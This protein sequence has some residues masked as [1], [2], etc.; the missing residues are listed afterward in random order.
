[1]ECLDWKY[2][3]CQRTARILA[4]LLWFGGNYQSLGSHGDGDE[5]QLAL[6]HLLLYFGTSCL[7]DTA[8]SNSSPPSHLLTPLG[9][10]GS[11]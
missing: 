8:R 4:W 6:V 3:E 1:M 9:R 2:G 11:H 7:L 10:N 5:R